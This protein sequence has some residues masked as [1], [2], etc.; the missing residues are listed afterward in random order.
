MEIG[1]LHQAEA[2]ELR[3]QAGEADRDLLHAQ[4]P[5]GGFHSG[6]GEAEHGAGDS[7]RQR[8]SEQDAACRIGDRIVSTEPARRPQ[9]EAAQVDEPE[10]RREQEADPH[11]QERHPHERGRDV[12]SQ[13][14]HDDEREGQDDRQRHHRKGQGSRGEGRKLRIAHQPRPQVVVHAPEDQDDD[15]E[16]GEKGKRTHD[17]GGCRRTGFGARVKPPL[18]RRRAGRAGP[19]R[20]GVR[21]WSDPG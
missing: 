10:E 20:R 14:A 11:P 18:P 15:D 19:H 5:E 9:R 13:A 8:A 3:R 12:A 6:A 17:P 1:D 16:E 7:D 21:G 4:P 2:I